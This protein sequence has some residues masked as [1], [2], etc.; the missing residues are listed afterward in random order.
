MS[1]DPSTDFLGL[2]RQTSGGMRSVRSPTLDVILLTLSNAG[3][4][5]MV[6]S[7]AAPVT[8]QA[9]T[10]WFIPSDPS[11]AAQGSLFLWDAGAAAYVPATPALFKALILAA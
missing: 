3:L 6:V 1:Y 8:N 10:A 9:T 11:W 7:A 5:D 4:F 2:L